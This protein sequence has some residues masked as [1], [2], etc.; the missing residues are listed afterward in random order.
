[1]SRLSHLQDRLGEQI[2]ELHEAV[3]IEGQTV[4]ATLRPRDGDELARSLGVLNEQGVP[5]LVRGHGTRTGLGNAPREVEVVVSTERLAG[6]DEFDAQDGVIQV[7][8]GT[9][10]TDVADTVAAAGWELPL[11]PPGATTSIGGAIASGAT[12]PCRQRF[13]APRDCILGLQVSLASGERTSCGGRVVKNVTGYDMA[14]LYAGSLGSLGVI[15]SA[16]LRL[17]PR[18]AVAQ[19][20]VVVLPGGDFEAGL[21]LGRAAARRSS[22]RVVALVSGEPAERLGAPTGGDSGSALVVECADDAASLENDMGWLQAEAGARPVPEA[23]RLVGRLRELQ[24]EGGLRARVGV[25]PSQLE[26]LCAL[27][28]DAGLATIVYPGLGLTYAISYSVQ[29]ASDSAPALEA[30]DEA[31]DRLEADVMFEELPLEARRSRDVFGDPGET[32]AIARSLKQRFDPGGIL[33]PG[34][35]QGRL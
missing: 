31:R 33:N 35:F 26:E 22:A 8:A 5:A 23:S 11:D 15:E 3:A 34:R 7:R 1:V 4:R 10:L 20:A 21:R 27:L 16:W 29:S 25:L 24:G 14:K 18:P 13:G 2:I 32:L 9:S 28:A 30:I 19:T 12:G 6:I 17:R